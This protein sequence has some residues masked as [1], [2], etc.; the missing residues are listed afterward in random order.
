[1]RINK[2]LS[3][4]GLAS[5]RKCEE[6]VING[7]IKVNGKIIKDLS[8]QID[9]NEDVVEYDTKIISPAKELKYLILH[10]P[11]GYLTTLKDPFKR[12]T[13]KDLIKD[14]PQRVFPVGRLDFDSEGLIFLTNDGDLANKLL[15]P[16]YKISKKYYVVLNKTINVDDIQILENGIEL[17]EGITSP[18]KIKIIEH[19]HKKTHLY[20]T[21]HQG[22]KRQIKR[23]FKVVGKKVIRLKRVEFASLKLGKLQKGMYRNLTK[24]EIELLKKKILRVF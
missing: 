10:K 9:E 20:I 3:K 18:A 21:I 23:M 16:K 1:M 2:Y 7:H 24:N 4:C 11:K 13:I 5:R 14:I 12:Q 22:W 6:F 17:E 19:K 8:Y 15:H